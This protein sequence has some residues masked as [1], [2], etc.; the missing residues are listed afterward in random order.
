MV[1]RWREL[2]AQ[3]DAIGVA[4]LS[5]GGAEMLAAVREARRDAPADAAPGL[6]SLERALLRDLGR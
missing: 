1:R 6:A 4:A 5:M 3:R 2:P